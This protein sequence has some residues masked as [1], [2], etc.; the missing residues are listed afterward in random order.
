ME[1]DTIDMFNNKIVIEYFLLKK[2]VLTENKLSEIQENIKYIMSSDVILFSCDP[3]SYEFMLKCFKQGQ[4][5]EYFYFNFYKNRPTFMNL[6]RSLL[7]RFTG[8]KIKGTDELI[9]KKISSYDGYSISK[10]AIKV[11]LNGYYGKIKVGI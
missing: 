7:Y 10:E 5:T 1:Q 8:N 2:N 6:C 9:K 11:I 3:A 4:K